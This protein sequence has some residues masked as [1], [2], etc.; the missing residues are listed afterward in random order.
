MVVVPCGFR[1]PIDPMGQ[2]NDRCRHHRYPNHGEREAPEGARRGFGRVGGGWVAD[3]A[4]GV[5]VGW[6]G[7]FHGVGG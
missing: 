5:V 6:R 2:P 1:L 7:W 4:L 3:D